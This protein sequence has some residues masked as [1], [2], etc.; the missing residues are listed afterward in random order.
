MGDWSGGMVQVGGA[1]NAIPW[2]G[3]YLAF[4]GELAAGFPLY[5]YE[6]FCS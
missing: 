2:I 4:A 3:T 5:S 1:T 6:W